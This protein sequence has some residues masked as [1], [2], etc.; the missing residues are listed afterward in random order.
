V[1]V[2]REISLDNSTK[3]LKADRAYSTLLFDLGNVVFNTDNDTPVRF[4]AD[5]RA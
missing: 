2:F 5:L 4:W 3:I 1:S